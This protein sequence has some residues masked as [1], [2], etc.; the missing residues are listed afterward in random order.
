VA[1]FLGEDTDPATVRDGMETDRG[2]AVAALVGA[3][4]TVYAVK[5]R[6]VDR[7]RDRHSSSGAKSERR[8]SHAPADMVRTEAH[9][10]RPIAGDRV[11][12]RKRSVRTRRRPCSST[13][14]TSWAT[15]V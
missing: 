15:R 8:R 6:Q 10:L 2:P 14:A 3:C 4:Y 5:P 7:Y 13:A 9:Q 11:R 12:D 1:E